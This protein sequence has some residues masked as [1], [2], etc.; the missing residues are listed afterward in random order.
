MG[1]RPGDEPT[2]DEREFS[3]DGKF[4]SFTSKTISPALEADFTTLANDEKQ[5]PF[6]TYQNGLKTIDPTLQ[7]KIAG[8]E[9]AIASA[10]EPTFPNA[11]SLWASRV[12]P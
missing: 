11:P 7:A 12:M 3:H 8:D 9:A 4:G 2:C 5:L 6:Q 10:G 1:A